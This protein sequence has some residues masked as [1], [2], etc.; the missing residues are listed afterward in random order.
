M[1]LRDIDADYMVLRLLQWPRPGTRGTRYA[2]LR[3]GIRTPCPSMMCNVSRCL[4]PSPMPFPEAA[5]PEPSGRESDGGIQH[6]P[7]RLALLK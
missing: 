7:R 1:I 4:P 2:V 6:A 5:T 3:R